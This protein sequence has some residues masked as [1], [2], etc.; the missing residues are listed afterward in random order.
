M[1][2]PSFIS[3][4]SHTHEGQLFWY[5]HFSLG[6]NNDTVK[7]MG[8]VDTGANCNMISKH[9][10]PGQYHNLIGRT[11]SSVK[12]IGGGQKSLGTITADVKI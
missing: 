7:Y 6:L 8:L 12:G 9:T 5:A 3:N 10:I 11:D 4:S 1:A 2:P